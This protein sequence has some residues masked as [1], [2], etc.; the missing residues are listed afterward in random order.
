MKATVMRRIL[1][2]IDEGVKEVTEVTV[3]NNGMVIEGDLFDKDGGGS[4]MAT[5]EIKENNNDAL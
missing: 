2:L 5:F 3:N 1:E 4:F